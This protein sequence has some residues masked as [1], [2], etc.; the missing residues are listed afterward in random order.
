M[1]ANSVAPATSGS[2]LEV[3]GEGNRRKKECRSAEEES[4]FQ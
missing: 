1:R 2:M 3:K 4:S